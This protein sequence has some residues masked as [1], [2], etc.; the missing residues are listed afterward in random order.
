MN[1]RIYRKELKTLENLAQKIA[2]SRFS[3]F[4][5]VSALSLV[6]LRWEKLMLQKKIV[7]HPYQL[8]A[9]MIRDTQ[10]W[11]LAISSVNKFAANTAFESKKIQSRHP[12]KGAI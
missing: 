1:R 8:A 4:G 12:W 5:K 2:V 7:G 6:I 10:N 11:M 9:A 3:L